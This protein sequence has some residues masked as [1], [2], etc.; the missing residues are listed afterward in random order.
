M[1]DGVGILPGSMN[2]YILEYSVRSGQAAIGFR[3]P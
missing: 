1:G 3:N 2:I